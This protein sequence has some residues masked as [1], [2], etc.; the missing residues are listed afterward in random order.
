M[1][2]IDTVTFRLKKTDSEL[3]Y[4]LLGY[5]NISFK[6]ERLRIDKLNSQL[7]QI[8]SLEEAENNQALQYELEPLLEQQFT[9][10]SFNRVLHNDLTNRQRTAFLLNYSEEYNIKE[11]A[12][13][14]GISP[15]TAKLHI[16]LALEKILF[17]EKEI[18]RG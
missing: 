17:K 9:N 1:I 11:V 14:M 13:I 16:D 4:A 2:F 10:E 12:E 8:Y 15:R 6:N 3:F 7:N 5:M 18:L